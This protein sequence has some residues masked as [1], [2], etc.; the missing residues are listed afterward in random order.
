ME[1]KSPYHDTIV[2]LMKNRIKYVSGGQAQRSYWLPT[3]GKMDNSD[4]ELYRTSEVYTSVRYGKDIMTADDTEGSK[5]SRTSGQVTLV[6][7]NPKLTLH[8]SAKLNVEMGKIHANQKYRAL[9]VGT[10]DGIKNFTSDAEAIAKRLR[11]RNRQQWCLD[12]RR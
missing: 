3:D 5:Y 1:T 7:N 2:N 9:I 8:E 6:V 11:E 4:V 10:A 12:F